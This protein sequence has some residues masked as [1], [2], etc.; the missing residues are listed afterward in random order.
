LRN[1]LNIFIIY[2]YNYYYPTSN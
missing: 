1:L 2:Y